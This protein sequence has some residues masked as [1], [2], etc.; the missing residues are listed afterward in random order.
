MFRVQGLGFGVTVH[1]ADGLDGSSDTAICRVVLGFVFTYTLVYIRMHGIDTYVLVFSR[2]F[3]YRKIG[4][5]VYIFTYSAT[6]SL[7]PTVRAH[8]PHRRRV[9]GQLGHGHLG[10]GG[11]VLGFAVR[12]V[13]GWCGTPP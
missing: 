11:W 4:V 12:E 13:Q 8:R 5:Y 1:T 6:A 9:R 7:S 10:V 3:I 2:R